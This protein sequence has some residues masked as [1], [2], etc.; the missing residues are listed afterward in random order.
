MPLAPAC[1]ASFGYSGS[2]REITLAGISCPPVFSDGAGVVVEGATGRGG[3]GAA[4][5][6]IS[7][8]GKLAEVG[9]LE[10]PM[11]GASGRSVGLNGTSVVLAGRNLC[12]REAVL[13]GFK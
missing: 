9:A 8:P 7:I 5:W 1:L 12:A 6:L 10:R 4:G 3:A 2:T 13:K 11:T